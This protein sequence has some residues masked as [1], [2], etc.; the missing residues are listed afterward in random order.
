VDFGFLQRCLAGP[1]MPISPECA[2][3]DLEPAIRDFD[4][5]SNDVTVFLGCF[6]GPN[7]PADPNCAP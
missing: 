4:V 1:H 2:V 5:D 7:I 3:A 6:S